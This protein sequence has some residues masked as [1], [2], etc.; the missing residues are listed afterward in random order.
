MHRSITRRD[1]LNGVALT[2]GAAIMPWHL[3][4]DLTQ[5]KSASY[6]PPALTGM[7][8]SHPGSFEAAHSL[9]D[10]TFWNSAGKPEDTGETYDL[11][12]VGG[13]ISGLAAAHYYRKAAGD[14]AR[15]LILDNHDDFGGHAKRN[16]FYVGN[17][18]RLGFGGTF[19]I[20]SPAPYSAVAKG[21]INELGIDVPSFPKYF[22]RNV[23]R[24]HGL[25][26]KI[27]FDKETFGADKLVVNYNP[28][29][30][31]ES[32]DAAEHSPALLKTFLREAPIADQAKHDLQALYE[33][34]KDYFPG[35]TSDEKKTKLARI[36][37][38]NY[39]KDVAGVHEDIAKLY[40]ALPHGLF[41]V[42][43]DAVSAQDAWG[44]DLPGFKGLKLDP[45]PGKGMNRDA[46]PND[47]AE[48]YFFHFPDGNATIARLL[49]R[50]LIPAAVPG[51]SVSD[52]ILAKAE[53]AKLD[54]SISPV[55]IRLNSTAVRVKHIGDATSGK[56]VEVTYA[57]SGKVYSTKASHAIL[58]CWHV[59]IPYI[60]QELP[61]KQKE[62]LSSA[63]K[64]PLLY[65]NVALKN[66]KS[67]VKAGTN[68]IYAP[69][70]YHTYVNLD[71]PVSI[72]GY[73]C[74]RKPDEPIVVHLMK[75]ACHPG[76]PTREQHSYGRIELFTTDFETIERS[77]REQLARMLASADFDP[78]RDIAAITVNRWPHGYAYEYNSLFDSF[79]LEGGETP[80][81]VA[82][83]P[84]GRI[85]IAN[86]DAGAY[87]YTDEAINQAH[88]AV[89]EITKS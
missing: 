51:N 59:V 52:V 58:A 63:Q 68:S 71:L 74:A 47:E 88:R 16:E 34:P 43:I 57:N 29:G 14:K 11:I 64:V 12:V 45:T 86:C 48:K 22:D 84:F 75:A 80:C 42:G 7:R 21:L 79:W 44:L 60:C 82:R 70:M 28:R 73:E 37:Y 9:R 66:W 65:T 3:F 50:Q 67:F 5:E 81:E 69:G 20:E 24:S 6:Y 78:A 30:G 1:F 38:A 35:L 77:I 19:S 10:G 17:A 76:L 8:G 31:G 33:D 61:D 2:A 89:S 40:Q 54:Q 27:F 49:V 56:E 53:Y 23:Y 83:K 32:E 26:P 46:I 55:R 62:A 13:G 39:L 36:S 41:G 87:A 4:G 15:I 18:F 25:K 72:G 85:A